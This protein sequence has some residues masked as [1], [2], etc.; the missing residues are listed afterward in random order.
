M[1]TR[2]TH[3]EPFASRVL[4]DYFFATPALRLRL[5]LVQEH[6]RCGDTAVLILGESGAGKST[7]L[8][9]LVCRSDH[10]WRVVRLPAVPSFSAGD[11]ITFLNAELRLPTRVSTVDQPSHGR[12]DRQGFPRL[13]WTNKHDGQRLA[14]RRARAGAMATCFAASTTYIDAEHQTIVP[15]RIV[16]RRTLPYLSLAVP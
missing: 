11:V 8:N 7:L 6:I 4:D 16:S 13:S 3:R 12:R 5:D 1:Q 10:N 15:Y 9:Q 14:E 2:A